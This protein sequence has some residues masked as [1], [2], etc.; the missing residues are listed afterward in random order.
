MY[1]LESGI[2]FRTKLYSKFRQLQLITHRCPSFSARRVRT[3][4][5]THTR[6]YISVTGLISGIRCTK[7]GEGERKP[8]ARQPRDSPEIDFHLALGTTITRDRSVLHK[9][10]D[11]RLEMAVPRWTR[12]ANEIPVATDRGNCPFRRLVGGNSGSSMLAY[13]FTAGALFLP[14]VLSA[15]ALLPAVPRFY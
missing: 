11:R 4:I 6:V 14:L 8:R 15:R 13:R 1:N 5:H 7:A 3:H 10:K 9:R 12:A 2:W